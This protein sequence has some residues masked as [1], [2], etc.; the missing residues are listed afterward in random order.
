MKTFKR[1]IG[2]TL[3][4]LTLLATV[5]MTGCGDS[6]KL[7]EVDA[8]TITYDGEKI[9][10]GYATNAIKYS[11]TINGTE[12]TAFDTS[13]AHRTDSNALTVSVC[14]IGMDENVGETVTKSFTKLPTIEN[15]YFS[16]D[17][18][19]SW[20]PITGASA[21]I[22]KV[23]GRESEMI[24]SCSYNNFE[25]GKV[26][27]ISV[28]PT[29]TDNS[30]FSY[31]SSEASKTYLA[32]PTAI[33]FDGSK[34]T[35]NGSSLAD[36]YEVLINGVPFET[37]E[38]KSYTMYDANKSTFDLSMRS[39]GDGVDSFS[40]AESTPHKYVFL[41]DV[42][43]FKVES[44]AISWDPVPDA[45]S[46]AI[47]I[48]GTEQ[49]LTQPIYKNLISGRDNIIKVKPTAKSSDKN[50]TYFSEWSE[51][52]KVHILATPASNWNFDYNLDGQAMTAFFWTP[53]S[54]EV[55]GYEVKVEYPS[56]ESE[57]FPVAKDRDNF[58]FAFADTGDYKVSVKAVADADSDVYDSAYSDTIHVRRLAP[59]SPDATNFIISDAKDI[60][61]GFKIN[62]ANQG[63]G[64]KYS[65][66][67]EGVEI[68]SK[69][70][71]SSITVTN[72]VNGNVTTRQELTYSAQAI[73]SGKFETQ[74]GN[75]VVILSSLSSQNY[76]FTVTVLETPVIGATPINGKI[77]SW[78]AVT[79]ADGYWVDGFGSGSE[80]R[81]PQCDLAKIKTAGDYSL[82]VCARGN[83]ANVLASPYT[84]AVRVRKLAAP[85]NIHVIRTG[86]S[87][88]K[89]DFDEVRGATGYSI[90]FNGS[91]EPIDVYTI[92]N[93]NDYITTD[94]V[95][96]RVIAVA[97][98]YDGGE[99]I[100][101]LTSEKSEPAL[102][103]AQLNAPT[104]PTVYHDEKNLLWVRPSNAS[105]YTPGY[106]VYSGSGL[107][108]AGIYNSTSFSLESFEPGTYT[109]SIQ[110]VGDG[111]SWLNSDRSDSIT[112]TKLASPVVETMVAD[113]CYRWKGVEG[114][115][116]YVVRVNGEIVKTVP[117]ESG[118][119]YYY[120]YELDPNVFTRSAT[121]TVSVTAVSDEAMDSNPTTFTQ[122]VNQLSAPSF[123]LS[124]SHPEFT[125]GG[126]IIVNATATDPNTTAFVFNVGGTRSE[127]QES[128]EYRHTANA[129]TTYTV[130]VIAVGGAFDANKIYYINSL[131]AT[132][133]QITLLSAPGSTGI[134]LTPSGAVAT[135]TWQPV[136]K[137]TNG[138]EIVVDFND[139]TEEYVTTTSGDSTSCSFELYD[140]TYNPDGKFKRENLQNYTYKIRALGNAAG[141]II[142]SEYVVW[143]V[144]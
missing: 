24:T 101:C 76:E 37:V 79:G 47:M 140:A 36:G 90:F 46:Y 53:V 16:E 56:G 12:Y 44:G 141:T 88:G 51:E 62:L 60:N 33:K 26:N 58:G 119:D 81:T 108:F 32:A 142:A 23:N 127:P 87:E 59:P 52:K 116:R 114:A 4:V 85:T 41:T 115:Q 98:S 121:Y 106:H 8:A 49:T 134:K 125:L 14:P 84:E 117:A 20:D 25:A 111:T 67:K 50:V 103:L 40:S 72:V 126:Q 113:T 15:L 1:I 83:G 99:Q 94:G 69:S 144:T 55:S 10:W 21:Y 27:K 96:I 95:S 63:V 124:Y 109:F 6:A 22:V 132:N 97:D 135:L 34:I 104:F 3:L 17:G 2:V 38:G 80:E 130:N 133:K 129:T 18:T 70:Q 11:V 120:T 123:T 86:E 93:V 128:G 54:G 43:N 42:S 39:L 143:T 122:E 65:I 30:T 57:A 45:T 82:K 138:Y 71:S 7:G 77:L 89:I 68:V 66:F 91:E 92:N 139:G 64:V 9:S 29:S 137:A 110:A 48:N 61:A 118:V 19:L 35:W 31:W 74:N 78:G 107:A 105:N 112:I 100:H 28:R 75:K 102:H 131:P 13:I 136:D 73:G 5:L